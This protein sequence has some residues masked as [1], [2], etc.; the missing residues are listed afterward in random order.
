MYSKHTIPVDI[1]DE[2]SARFIVNLN[3][4][5][6]KNFVRIC[7]QIEEAHWFYVDFYVNKHPERRLQS[8]TMNT[9]AEHIF[10]HV[11]FLQPHVDKLEDIL[12][13]W[14]NYKL[15]VPTYGAIIL[16]TF[17]DKVLLVQAFWAKSS[18]GFPKG[19]INQEE[20]PHVCAAREVYE[21]TGYD[22]SEKINPDEYFDHTLNEQSVRLYIVSGVQEDTPFHPRSRCEIRDIK[23]FDINSLPTNKSDQTCKSKNG[24][25][26]NSFYM[27]IPF[28]RD[29][30]QYVQ[31]KLWERLQFQDEA[32]DKRGRSGR[33][34]DAKTPL[35]QQKD[36]KTP[37]RKR[38]DRA[39][40]ES[41]E[42]AP[43]SGCKSGRKSAQGKKSRRQLF[44]SGV[45]QGQEQNSVS[46]EN[47]TTPKSQRNTP[48]NRKS[49]TKSTPT[50]LHQTG[51]TP[52]LEG[53]TS[54]PSLAATGVDGI[55]REQTNQSR[56]GQSG[57][58]DRSKG[59]KECPDLLPPNFCPK[60]WINFSL[61]EK[62]L[63]RAFFD[64]S[65]QPTVKASGEVKRVRK[66]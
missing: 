18:W 44:E 23:W 49:S 6:R 33:K 59:Q 17:L 46:R 65:T 51:M 31:T 15:S 5:E 48:K 19:K 27:V 62:S 22:I 7:F 28:M 47:T 12:T 16:N 42:I 40:S 37:A 54:N 41:L 32:V 55:R 26:P 50:A 52:L 43:L 21:E 25:S 53:K 13:S 30:K 39:N 56:G 34:S 10:R 66:R 35:S 36:G 11:A 8:G 1:L 29:L 24:F 58:I 63:V 45:N 61:D 38:S 9:F 60:A 57:N 20:E 4:E 2:I 64:L 14:R 3:E